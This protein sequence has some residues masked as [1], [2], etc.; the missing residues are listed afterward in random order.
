MITHYMKLIWPKK[1]E[2]EVT[3]I[4]YILTCILHLNSF[5]DSQSEKKLT[6]G[7]NWMPQVAPTSW[8]TPGAPMVRTVFIPS[9]SE[10]ALYEKQSF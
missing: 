6:G 5:R 3:L 1:T 10:Y 4:A 9:R 2:I 8:A 7:A